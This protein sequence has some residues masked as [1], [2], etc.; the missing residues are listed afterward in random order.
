VGQR[1]GALVIAFV[2]PG[3]GSQKVG[4]GKALAEALPSARA[5]YAEADEALGFAL[6]RLCFEGPESELQLTANTQPAILATSMAALCAV[7]EQGIEPAVVAG[8]SLGEYSALVAAGAL[9]FADAVR[10]VNLRGRFMQEAVPAGA[11]AMAAIVG[12]DASTVAETCL[13]ALDGDAEGVC[14]PANFNGA[15]QVVIAG[16]AGPVERA[17]ALAKQKGAKLVKALPVSAPF[18]CALMQPAAE[19]LAVE[20]E[21]VKVGPLAVPVVT[22]VEA[23]ENR[24]SSRVKELLVR[25]VTGTVRWEESAQRLV[26]M[27]VTRLVEIGPGRVLTTL[28]KRIAP[29]VQLHNV[30][31]P[32]DAAALATSL[33]EASGG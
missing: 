25:Q 6:S 23:A 26:A 29:S 12:F 33:K 20:L 31:A 10:L 7:R 28:M 11:G 27:G 5:L 21:R 22:N 1:A 8:H 24:D 13:E 2:F 9:R 18:H 30:E 3:Q 17:M 16:H 19:R 32:A 4:M 15:G 14:A